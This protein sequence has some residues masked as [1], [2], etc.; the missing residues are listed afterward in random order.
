MLYLGG[1]AN[2]PPPN[3]GHCTS[4]GLH[5]HKPESHDTNPIHAEKT[6]KNA[7]VPATKTS[8]VQLELGLIAEPTRREKSIPEA[9]RVV[10]ARLL[11][12][13]SL[14]SLHRPGAAYPQSGHTS[15]AEL[16]PH[17]LG[18]PLTLMAASPPVPVRRMALPAASRPLRTHLVDVLLRVAF[19][20]L[21]S[22]LQLGIPRNF[23]VLPNLTF[24]QSLPSSPPSRSSVHSSSNTNDSK[25][26]RA[27]HRMRQ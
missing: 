12:S 27:A 26:L 10:H 7:A 17:E 20:H 5:S 19:P 13:S 24:L 21:I 11:S 15:T 23:T 8:P 3:L 14:R 22:L 4:F 16:A 6:K 25:G 2:A 9:T 1:Y 18:T